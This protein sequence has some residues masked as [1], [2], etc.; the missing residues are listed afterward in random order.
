MWVGGGVA[1]GWEG[2]WHVGGRGMLCSSVLTA[3]FFRAAQHGCHCA[4]S[5]ALV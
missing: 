1:C 3:V 2:V 5:G 4:E